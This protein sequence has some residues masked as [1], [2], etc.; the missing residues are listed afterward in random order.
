M[1][2]NHPWGQ[3]IIGQ[4]LK[5]THAV[6]DTSQTPFSILL[7]Q[8]CI[9]CSVRCYVPATLVFPSD[10]V[11]VIIRFQYKRGFVF[12]M[13]TEPSGSPAA[14]R[15]TFM[16]PPLLMTSLKGHIA[17]IQTPVGILPPVKHAHEHLKLLQDRGRNPNLS[18]R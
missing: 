14:H 13:T 7:V 5:G 15:Q 2:H 9:L 3:R 16:S 6:C 8:A 10:V 4:V 11:K 12:A 17:R 18:G 1:C